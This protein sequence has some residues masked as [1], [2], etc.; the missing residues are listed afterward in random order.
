MLGS[1]P[2]YTSACV[3]IASFGRP[4]GLWAR[5]SHQ[6]VLRACFR[7]H[8]TGSTTPLERVPLR[9]FPLRWF[10]VTETQQRGLHP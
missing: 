7:A 1:F 2:P 5:A 10:S 3:L 6:L 8:R 9:E 4:I